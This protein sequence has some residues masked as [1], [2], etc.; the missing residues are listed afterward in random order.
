MIVC[1]ADAEFIDHAST[2]EH[3]SNVV[4]VERGFQVGED[5][6]KEFVTGEMRASQQDMAECGADSIYCCIIGETSVSQGSGE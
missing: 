2:G 3:G 1:C 5:D 6:P 4:T